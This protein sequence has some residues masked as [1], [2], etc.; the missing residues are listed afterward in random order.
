MIEKRWAEE[1]GHK[2]KCLKYYLKPSVLRNTGGLGW[3]NRS[4]LE[5][6]VQAFYIDIKTIY[7]QMN[8]GCD[9][10]KNAVANTGLV[11]L[12]FHSLARP[13]F[14]SANHF[15]N[16]PPESENRNPGIRSPPRGPCENCKSV[17]G[18]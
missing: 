8:V 1:W 11:K 16:L 14:P 17:P 6:K 13:A 5:K 18:F 15:A 7:M 9:A 3:G 4:N 10:Y 12:V 2:V